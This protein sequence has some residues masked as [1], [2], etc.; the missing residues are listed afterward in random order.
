VSDFIVGSVGVG[1]LLAFLA[2][3]GAEDVREQERQT[4]E[5]CE[6]VELWKSSGGE[7]GWPAYK[8]EEVCQ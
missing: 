8:S 3:A 1:V 6:M 5:Y 7:N 4:T 2:V